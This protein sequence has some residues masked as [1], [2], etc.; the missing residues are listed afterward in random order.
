MGSLASPFPL[1]TEN[2]GWMS[3]HRHSYSGLHVGRST[4]EVIRGR[5]A[6]CQQ[7]E[8]RVAGTCSTVHTEFGR[9]LVGAICLAGPDLMEEW[10]SHVMQHALP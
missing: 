1:I 10:L 7:L 8:L 6:H 3:S 9:A 2:H 4:L 5:G